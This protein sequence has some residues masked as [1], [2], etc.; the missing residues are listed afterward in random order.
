MQMG[1]AWWCRGGRGGADAATTRAL[2]PPVGSPAASSLA[3]LAA[4]LAAAPDLGQRLAGRTH[5]PLGEPGQPRSA[6]AR[7]VHGFARP[8][9]KSP[10]RRRPADRLGMR[11][12]PSLGAP[13]LDVSEQHGKDPSKGQESEPFRRAAVG[14]SQR[15]TDAPWCAEASAVLPWRQQKGGRQHLWGATSPQPT[16]CTLWS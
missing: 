10:R 3:Q 16:W 14:A 11:M 4:Q 6:A 15:G 2:P 13:L 8:L 1:C 5:A 7:S 9:A 12:R